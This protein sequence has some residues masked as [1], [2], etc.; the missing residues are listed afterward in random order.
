M[1]CPS[2]GKG[3]ES[4]GSLSHQETAAH[5]GKPPR[6][7]GPWDIRTSIL[8]FQ[9]PVQRPADLL[10][11]LGIDG[12]P[13]ALPVAVPHLAQVVLRHSGHHAEWQKFRVTKPFYTFNQGTRPG[14]GLGSFTQVA[15]GPTSR[16]M[17]SAVFC[18]ALGLSAHH[19]PGLHDV[20]CSRPY[21]P[22]PR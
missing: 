4:L 6:W 10:D 16:E 9:D 1:P 22:S 21:Q 5:S 20:T 2:N 11:A 7:S 13:R 3:R 8:L 17:S 18:H 19:S 12:T 15:A 14:H